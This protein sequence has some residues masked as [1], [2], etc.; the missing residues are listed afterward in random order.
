MD[1]IY[2]Y[3]ESLDKI[4][5]KNPNKKNIYNVFFPV[6]LRIRFTSF[7]FDVYYDDES[8]LRQWSDLS[9]YLCESKNGL[10]THAHTY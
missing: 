9:I 8:M 3:I 7:N 10:H 2:S 4:L 6:S 1:V 5:F